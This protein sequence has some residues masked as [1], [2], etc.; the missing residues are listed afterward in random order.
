MK[1]CPGIFLSNGKDKSP[2]EQ[3]YSLKY[4]LLS[5]FSILRRY[6]R[7]ITS[8]ILALKRTF[9]KLKNTFYKFKRTFYKLN[10]LI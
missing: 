5:Y 4:L 9:Y 1:G 7:L 3:T 2:I 6:K 8:N 10:K